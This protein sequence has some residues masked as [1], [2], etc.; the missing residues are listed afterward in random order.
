MAQ[1]VK[2]FEKSD[3][4]TSALGLFYL[5][6]GSR[7][8][9]GKLFQAVSRNFKG[10]PRDFYCQ[11]RN[12][13][14]KRKFSGGNKAKRRKGSS[15]RGNELQRSSENKIL[16]V[17]LFICRINLFVCCGGCC[18]VRRY[19]HHVFWCVLANHFAGTYAGDRGIAGQKIFLTSIKVEV[20]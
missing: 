12:F 20:F 10:S 7:K 18:K 4:Q 16:K 6:Q 19:A 5:T 1:P 15:G 9:N 11:T 8:K 13:I 2:Q 3:K 17:K 14:Q